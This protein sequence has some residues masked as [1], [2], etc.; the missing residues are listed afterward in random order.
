MP[1]G[2]I[3]ERLRARIERLLR[4]L[5]LRYMVDEDGDYQLFL[6]SEE[7]PIQLRILIVREGLMREILAF[8]VRFEG[9]IP[10]LTEEEALRLVNQWNS[11]RRWPR[12]FWREGRFYGDFHMDAETDIPQAFLELNFRHFL[13]A[14]LQ[15][16][17]QLLGREEE[18]IRR[19]RQRF[20]DDP[21]LN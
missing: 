6:S 16:A 21:R 10:S 1:T 14:S 18:L 3:G 4:K 9:D 13:G 20:L 5:K 17:L 2:P 11:S 19:W 8:I 7:I 12:L 15:F